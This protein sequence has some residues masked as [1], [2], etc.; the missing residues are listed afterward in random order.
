VGIRAD[1]VCKGGRG[2]CGT[3]AKGGCVVCGGSKLCSTGEKVVEAGDEGSATLLE[4]TGSESGLVV[5]S[6]FERGA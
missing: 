3:I 4:K 1:P 5:G 2:G 6:T